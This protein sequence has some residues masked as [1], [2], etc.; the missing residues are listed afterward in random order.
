MS[1]KN[2]IV[3]LVGIGNYYTHFLGVI[4]MIYVG[5]DISKFNHYASI[6][7]D[8]GEIIREPFS[9]SNNIQGFSELFNS[10]INFDKENIIIGFESTS[11]YGINFLNFFHKKGFKLTVINPI[12]TSNFRRKKIRP[13]K[14][15]KIDSLNIIKYLRDNNYTL[16]QEKDILSIELKHYSLFRKKQKQHLAKLK[17]NLVA[18]LDI[19]FPE[20]YSIFPSG[21]HG[22]ASYSLLKETSTPIE[23]SK[24]HLRKLTN[25]LSV[26]SKGRF[27]QSKAVQLRELAKN[28]IGSSLVSLSFQ[29]KHLIQQIEFLQKQ[30][31]ETESIISN[32]LKLVDSPIKSIPGVSET[33]AA[34]LLGLLPNIELFSSP[35]K[36]VAF[37]GL[38]PVVKQSGNFN[39]TQTRMSKRGSKLLRY[40]LINVAWQLSLNNDVFSKYYAL[41]RNQGKKHYNALGHLASKLVR[42]IF[43]LLKTNSIFDEKQLV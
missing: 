32:L 30:I 40:T 21:I 8:T 7:S 1:N 2:I 35:D 5:V 41:K 43:K 39:A 14:T 22:K 15:D 11:I 27:K 26:N 12:E 36:L 25:I 3:I 10:L 20:F 34:N 37:C 6:I 9:F 17:T 33:N 19:V 38:D 13:S 23:I 31:E 29:I 28:S 18:N 16:F 4:F 24:M 42:I